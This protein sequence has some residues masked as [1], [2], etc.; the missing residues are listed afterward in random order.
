MQDDCALAPLQPNTQRTVPGDARDERPVGHSGNR[1]SARDFRPRQTRP[2]ICGTTGGVS[3]RTAVTG[4]CACAV[5]GTTERRAAPS[6][7]SCGPNVI[8]AVGLGKGG[9]RQYT[10]NC[11]ASSN[12]S[13]H[14]YNVQ[15]PSDTRYKAN[16]FAF[17]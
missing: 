2:A 8:C 3:T 17:E 5:G 1:Q 10:K 16:A 14:A 15:Y 12:R 4:M 7:G 11:T 13:T 6:I 9:A